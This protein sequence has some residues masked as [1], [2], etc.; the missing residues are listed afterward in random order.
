MEITAL[1]Y[2]MAGLSPLSVF[3][4]CK[5]QLFEIRDADGALWVA[6]RS[7][8]LSWGFTTLAVGLRHLRHSGEVAK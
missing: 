2:P 8:F 3:P 4:D 5:V 1:I 6:C 7:E